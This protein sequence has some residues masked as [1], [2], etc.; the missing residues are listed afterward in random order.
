M[1]LPVILLILLLI[2]F[3][4]LGFGYTAS[5]QGQGDFPPE[6]Q[7]ALDAARAALAAFTNSESYSLAVTQ[8]MEQS[9]VFVNA[10]ESFQMDQVISSEGSLLFQRA[11]G[12]PYDN[13]SL[14]LT[15]TMTQTMSSPTIPQPQVTEIGPNRTRLIVADGRIYLRLD[16]TPELA[17]FIP[18]GWQD[19]TDGASMFPG[20]EMASLQGMLNTGQALSFTHLDTFFACVTAV[21]SLDPDPADALAASRTRLALDSACLLRGIGSETLAGIFASGVQNTVDVDA[22]ISALFDNPITQYTIE[23]TLDAQGVMIAYAEHVT[24]DS[25]ITAALAP[26]NLG[27]DVTVTLKQDI[28]QSYRIEETGFPVAITAPDLGEE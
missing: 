16:V 27:A 18:K 12:Q 23:I 21:E 7:A 19:V 14:D 22:F 28:H 5:V 6:E 13:R 17:A 25:D 11:P 20:M 26:S 15:Q 10:A 9:F 3:G 2:L 24:S 1:R 8:N 4:W